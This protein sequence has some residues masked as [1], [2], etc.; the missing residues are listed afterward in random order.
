MNWD[1]VAN[2]YF[3][4]DA[5]LEAILASFD[6]SYADL[7]AFAAKNHWMLQRPKKPHPDDLGNLASALAMEMF[8]I[9]KLA[10]R[11]RR[12]VA[13]MTVLGARPIDIAEVLQVDLVALQAEFGKE[14]A[15]R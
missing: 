3:T 13:A 14:L 7:L 1:L 6:L 9:E 8:G 2:A 5:S 10:D 15:R 11:P 12:F 4:G